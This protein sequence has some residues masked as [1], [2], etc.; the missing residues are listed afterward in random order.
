VFRP[1]LL[2][3]ALSSL[4]IYLFFIIIIIILIWAFYLL[5]LESILKKRAKFNLSPEV[6][7]DFQFEP[8]SFKIG[9]LPL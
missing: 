9:S 6:L 1:L 7:R 8:Q 2:D 4:F 5:V 3:R